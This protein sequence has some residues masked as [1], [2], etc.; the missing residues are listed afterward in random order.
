MSV[1]IVAEKQLQA[2][3]SGVSPVNNQKQRHI[4]IRVPISWRVMLP[5]AAVIVLQGCAGGSQEQAKTKGGDSVLVFQTGGQAFKTEPKAKSDT[6]NTLPKI[7]VPD[8]KTLQHYNPFKGTIDD[9]LFGTRDPQLEVFR[10]AWMRIEDTE[11]PF[12]LPEKVVDSYSPEDKAELMR[13]WEIAKKEIRVAFLSDKGAKPSTA[14]QVHTQKEINE[15][16]E[17]WEFLRKIDRTWKD[18][19]YP[20]IKHD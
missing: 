2:A 7:V 6:L 14:L 1:Y 20:M 13:R 17:R 3:K 16:L 8:V 11:T 4:K 18:I 9:S 10:R 19:N 12:G 15:L 5:L